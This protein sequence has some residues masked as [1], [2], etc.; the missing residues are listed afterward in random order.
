MAVLP[1]APPNPRVCLFVFVVC[2]G[3][4]GFVGVWDWQPD[5]PTSRELPRGEYSTVL[6]GSSR[7]LLESSRTTGGT[8]NGKVQYISWFTGES[9]E[10]SDSVVPVISCPPGKYRVPSTSDYSKYSGQ[11][12]EGCHFCPRGKYGEESGLTSSSCSADCPKGRY[13]DTKGAITAEDCMLCPP[14]KVGDDEG[15]MTSEC[16]GNCEDGY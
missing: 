15:F 11:R 10:T 16:G 8:W 1:A 6:T 9:T 12:I 13:R 2:L 7:K 3:I 5:R 4:L 14:G